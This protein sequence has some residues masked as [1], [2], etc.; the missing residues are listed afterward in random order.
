MIKLVY[1]IRDVK[2][3][4]RV[5]ISLSMDVIVSEIIPDIVSVMVMK[6]SPGLS[7]AML[8]SRGLELEVAGETISDGGTIGDGVTI[9]D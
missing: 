4:E 7:V 8:E 9:G 3:I 1:Q 2:Y 6:S 5:Y